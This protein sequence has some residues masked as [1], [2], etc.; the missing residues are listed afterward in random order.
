MKGQKL[1]ALILNS[2]KKTLL[3]ALTVFYNTRW[4]QHDI[5]NRSVICMD[6]ENSGRISVHN[7]I[8]KMIP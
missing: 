5:T 6:I 8:E 4:D 1:L 3:H 7:P 2:P